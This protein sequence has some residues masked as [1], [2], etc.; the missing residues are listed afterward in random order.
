MDTPR[1]NYGWEIP[2]SDG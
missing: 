1:K 2:P